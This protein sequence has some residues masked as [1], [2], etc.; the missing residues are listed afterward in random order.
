MKVYVNDGTSLDALP[1]LGVA[2]LCS[3]GLTSVMLRGLQCSTISN[4]SPWR[5]TRLRLKQPLRLA[6]VLGLCLSL[7]VQRTTEKLQMNHFSFS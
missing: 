1:G 6:V 4:D 5:G 2:I 3:S 7:L